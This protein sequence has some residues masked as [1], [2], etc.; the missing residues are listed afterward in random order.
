MGGS[1]VSLPNPLSLIPKNPFEGVS[2]NKPFGDSAASNL[3]GGAGG[4]SSMF[5]NVSWE[6]PTGRGVVTGTINQQKKPAPEQTPVAWNPTGPG[7]MPKYM[8]SDQERQ[9][10]EA[11]M[12]SLNPNVNFLISGEKNPTSINDAYKAISPNVTGKVK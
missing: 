11:Y 9:F 6:N 3:V 2:W 5:N 12:K 10:R 1:G 7:A 4:V 8:P